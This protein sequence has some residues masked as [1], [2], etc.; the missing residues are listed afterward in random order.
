[1]NRRFRLLFQ[2]FCVF[3]ACLILANSAYTLG[4]QDFFGEVNST[5]IGPNPASV[6]LIG[7][8][9]IDYRTHAYTG[10]DMQGLF[11][12][13]QLRM[14]ATSSANVG[15]EKYDLAGTMNDG[16]LYKK[17]MVLDYEVNFISGFSFFSIGIGYG[18]YN[19]EYSNGT[20]VN[21]D[22]PGTAV[23]EYGPLKSLGLAVPVDVSKSTE[24]TTQ[25]NFYFAIP[26]N[27]LI[28]GIKYQEHQQQYKYEKL[29][30]SYFYGCCSGGKYAVL[31]STGTTKYKTTEYGILLPNLVTG[32]DLGAIHRPKSTATMSFDNEYLTTDPSL[33][34]DAAYLQNFDFEEP[35]FTGYGLSVTSGWGENLGL[36][37]ALDL[38]EFGK[39]E[40]PKFGHLPDAG[41]LNGQ[42]VRMIWGS[43]LD[44]K[45]GRRVKNYLG[46][47]WERNFVNLRLP[48][49][50]TNVIL[51]GSERLKLSDKYGQDH[52]DITFL[53]AS[54]NIKFGSRS[55][56]S[57][58][59]NRCG[60]V[61][62]KT[63]R[64]STLDKMRIADCQ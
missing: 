32:L 10:E 50:D 1:V 4:P 22:Y 33:S 14:V 37:F 27:Y 59:E 21:K 45:Y 53:T 25:T 43:W 63:K 28:L 13:E 9:H 7:R 8:N 51:V 38:G 64:L 3:G 2:G 12:P 19:A 30:M 48:I 11:F 29:N 5:R 17:G 57:S 58:S 20:Y 52:F 31:N 24:L 41:S 6:G 26:M 42:M 39:V 16:I 34:G 61:A 62:P 56:G 40:K 35:A 44:I 23:N 46:Y 36:A 18:A 49:S 15:E 60:S 47:I 55:S 54:I